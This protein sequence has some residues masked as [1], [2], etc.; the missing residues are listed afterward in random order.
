MIRGATDKRL[1]QIIKWVRALRYFS[2]GVIVGAVIRLLI[3]RS[4]AID[5]RE[6]GYPESQYHFGDMVDAP[7]TVLLVGFIVLAASSALA[8]V[9]R[10]E[11][12]MYYRARKTPYKYTWLESRIRNW[13]REE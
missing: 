11:F 9:I 1:L 7:M 13:L 10:T 3:I 5:N 12:D 8:A 6:A 4:L 2:V